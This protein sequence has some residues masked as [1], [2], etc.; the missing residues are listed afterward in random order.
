MVVI[1]EENELMHYGILRKS[2]RYPWG[3]GG[4]TAEQRSRD[5]LDYI[6][7]LKR[8]LGWSDV[9]ICKS[10][11]DE[12]HRF[13]T[14]DLRAARAIAKHEIR[15]AE[16]SEALR[17]KTKGYSNGAIATKMGLPGESS[18]RALLKGSEDEDKDVLR[19]TANMLRD[20]VNEKGILDV[21]SGVENYIGVSE[22][23]KNTALAMLVEEGYKIEYVKVPQIAGKGETTIKVL[24]PGDM[25][26]SEIYRRRGEI[27]GV[28]NFSD[29]GGRT[30][31]GIAEPLSLNPKRLAITYKEDG[32]AEA[33]G[34]IYV[35]PGV[36]DVSLGGARYAQVR[37]K[38]GDHHYVKGMA[39]YKNDLPEGVDLVFNTNKSDTGN[40]LDALKDMRDKDGNIDPD[41]P[42]G[43]YIR[44]QIIQKGDDGIERSVSVMNIVNEEG[45]WGGGGINPKTGEPYTDW[46]KSIASQVLSKQ[47]P[48]LAKS[49]LDMTYSQRE[50]EFNEIKALTNPT[51]RKKLLEE[52]A[53]GTDSAAVHLKAA[54][55]PRQQ[56]QVIMPVNTLGDNEI[57]A[58]NFRDGE[59]V[60]LIRYPHGGT[61]EIPEL[62]VNNRHSDSIKLLGSAQDVVGINARVAERLSGADF[63]GDT[64]L[65]IPNNQRRVRSSPAL[66]Q[67]K[68]FYP[69]SSY[70]A[71]E[72]MARISEARKQREMGDVSNLITDMT[73]Q[74]ASHAEIA[75]AVRHSMVV[76]DSE[77]HNLNY[78]QSALDNNIR[79][80][81]EKYQGVHGTRGA[82]TL[83]SRA[84]SVER[85][86][87]RVARRASE[88]G[89]V[90]PTTGRKV[91]T[92]TNKTYINKK[93][94]EVP[95]TIKSKKLAE[96][97]DANLLSSGTPMERLYA[98]HS[99]RLK[100]M[101]NQA[102]LA[103]LNTPRA[104]YSPSAARVYSAEVTSLV[105]KLDLAIRN[106]PLERQA[107]VYANALFRQRKDSNPN[108][109]DETIRKIKY[110]ILTE[111]RR[112]TGAS[113][114]R[115]EITEREWEAIQAGA[116]SD[117]R[118]TDILNNANMDTVRALA[119]P[120]ADKA[121]STAERQRAQAMLASGYTQAQVAD[122]IGVST[123]TLSKALS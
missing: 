79:Q 4:N 85:V 12:N 42:F 116:I 30:F 112:R 110:Q 44:R 67:L 122:A 100:D 27:K 76:I 102:R 83:I 65:V 69:Q 18:V 23:R 1:N 98:T 39:I 32:G 7:D 45:N 29:D 6:D 106:R 87:D 94:K 103:A 114:S 84:G 62:T 8:R 99:N 105:S 55:L 33:D 50:Q 111:A 68:G 59:R 46:S 119:T 57:Y 72:G 47:T 21:G 107:Q 54:N 16:T 19:S 75:R 24:V 81:K 78:K 34:V 91:Y 74:N 10:L 117:S 66:A 109:D 20:Q 5:F 28:T 60:A 49:Q 121:V 118:L 89:P 37:V 73:I 51:V 71:Y 90:D 36:D 88:G 101:A 92:Y 82:A 80:L 38:V 15:A 25:T 2:G 97:D 56:W 61:F 31:Y 35:R 96:V 40:K 52:F 120:R 86:P 53:D 43:S 104:T 48:Q 113:R 9:E 22:S 58:T 123:S 41:N 115:I 17:L 77:K 26:Y 13:S 14:T 70:P 3:S 63:D 64:V 108:M 95:N 11:S 93:G